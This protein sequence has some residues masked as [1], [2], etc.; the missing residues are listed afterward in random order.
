[1]DRH[2][3]SVVLRGTSRDHGY[4][5]PCLNEVGSFDRMSAFDIDLFIHLQH[6]SSSSQIYTIACEKT[7]SVGAHRS[8]NRLCTALA[9]HCKTYAL[10]FLL[11]CSGCEQLLP[12]LRF[13]FTH[14]PTLSACRCGNTTHIDLAYNVFIVAIDF[15]QPNI[16]AVGS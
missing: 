4:W 14:H 11:C 15:K 5:F 12:K 13:I 6:F 1:M 8:T 2:F 3:G 7:A 16:T 10:L 9:D